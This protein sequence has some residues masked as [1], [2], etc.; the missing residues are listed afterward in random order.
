M[1]KLSSAVSRFAGV[2]AKHAHKVTSMLGFEMIVQTEFD[3]DMKSKIASGVIAPVLLVACCC[4]ATA[5][6]VVKI[7]YAGPITG[8]VAQ[9][10]K[11]GEN[12]VGRGKPGGEAV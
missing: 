5:Q 3:I 12:G 11:D 10:G 4:V 8:P 6:Q 2:V 7:G 1:D 9:V